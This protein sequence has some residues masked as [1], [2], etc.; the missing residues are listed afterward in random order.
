LRQSPLDQFTYEKAG[1]SAWGV[2]GNISLPLFPNQA[3]Y[4]A[5]TRRKGDLNFGGVL[6]TRDLLRAFLR[7]VARP[8]AL[9]SKPRFSRFVHGHGTN[10]HKRTQIDETINV[11]FHLYGTQKAKL[12]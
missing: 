3:P 9:F 7:Q 5:E 10:F 2:S 11:R 8:K 4:Q 6:T 12:R 1:E